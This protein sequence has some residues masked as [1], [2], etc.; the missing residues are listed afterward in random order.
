MDN[1]ISCSKVYVGIDVSSSSL[2][3]AVLPHQEMYDVANDQQ[4]VARLVDRLKNCDIELIVIEATGGYEIRVATELDDAGLPVVVVNPRQVRDFARAAGVL[5]KT[6]RIDAQILARFARDMRPEKRPIPSKNAR[7]LQELLTRREQLAK[8]RTSEQTRLKQARSPEVEQTVRKMLDFVEEQLCDLE[9][10]I[11]E[12]LKASD[13]SRTRERILK[14]TP[15]VG[16]VVSRTLLIDLPELG[17]LNRREIAKLVGVAPINR[18]SGQFR[19]RR[20][21]R[22]G[23]SRVRSK[24]YMAV[25]VGIRH[26]QIIKDFY[27]H[28]LA[29]G[30]PTKVALTACMR[31][32]LSILNTMIATETEWKKPA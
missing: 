11:D 12:A 31:K 9:A 32:L 15:G 24:L 3:V 28:L 30:K 18:D 6:D 4:G 22:G 10:Q 1:V 14:S 2:D 29:Q 5:E 13:V 17:L 7:L 16:P 8:M 26:N 19:G 23:R 21:I 20:M 27:N 25:L